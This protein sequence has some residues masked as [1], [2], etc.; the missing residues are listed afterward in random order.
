ML[1]GDWRRSVPSATRPHAKILAIVGNDFNRA[2]V[3]IRLQIGGIV[4]DG[5]LAAKFILNFGEGVGYVANLEWEKARP[6]VASAMRSR[7]LSPGP[8]VPLT[9]VLIV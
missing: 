1:P 7:T 8:L 3:A 9:F 5:V 2:V 6:P 4:G